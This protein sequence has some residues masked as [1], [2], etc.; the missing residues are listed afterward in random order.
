MRENAKAGPSKAPI[1]RPST[2][3]STIPTDRLGIVEVDRGDK[4]EDPRP[5]ER[6]TPLHPNVTFNMPY[7][8]GGTVNNVN[9]NIESQ[10]NNTYHG[11]PP[12]PTHSVASFNDAPVDRI[13]PCFMGREEDMHAI[14]SA[15]RSCD[16]GAPSRYAVWGMPGLGK[17]QLA[18]SYANV[19]FKAGHHTHV[20]WIPAM[21]LEKVNQGLVKVLDLTQHVDR[22]NPD[23]G[24]RLTAARLCLEQFD[25]H[26]K[27]LIILDDVTLATLDFLREHLPRQNGHGSILITTRTLEV[28]KAVASVAGQQH[29]VHELKA[30]STQ[31]SVA[32]LF[33]SAGIHSSATA[34]LESAQKF[35]KKIG[36]LPLAVE[37]AGSYMRRSGLIG[38]DQLETLYDQ[39]G[40]EEIIGWDNSLTTYQ[41][42]SVLTTIT[43]QLQRLGEIDRHL[44][45]LLQ[46]LSFL[47]LENIPLDIV[48]LGARRVARRLAAKPKDSLLCKWV[49]QLSNRSNQVV[50]ASADVSVELRP[51]LELVC[52]EKWLR[53]ALRHLEELSLAQPRYDKE[54][55]LHIH[56]LIQLVLQNSMTAD[57]LG[58]DPHCALAA[59]L[60]R[61]A[62]ETL[63]DLDSPDTWTEFE[64]FVPHLMALLKHAGKSTP[65][66]HN[67]NA[68]VAWYFFRRGR[69]DEAEA[70]YRR[71]L[72]GQEEG[73]GADHPST[74]GTVNN[75]A[76][77]Y[78]NQGRYTEAEALYQRALEGQEQ[79][80]GPDH[81]DTLGTVNNLAIVYEKQGKYAEAEELYQRALA[82]QEKQFGPD[83][84]I[85]LNTVNNLG[86]LYVLWGNY[87]E[88]E[89]LCKRG[90]EGFEQQLGADHPETLNTVNSIA[91]LYRD[92]GRY[93][94]ADTFYKRALAGQ[95]RQ[96]GAD[97][98]DT[99]ETINSL[100]NLRVQQGRLEEAEILF[101]R[102]LTGRV[103]VI[104][105]RHPDTAKTIDSL[106]RLHE[107]QGRFE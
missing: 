93:T 38:A 44:L 89:P 63:G 11:V 16:G 20:I 52:S 57:Q 61:G 95:Q 85:T 47:D 90:L 48:V 17:S 87:E 33:K 23:Q 99:L 37:Q 73:L 19:S 2:V 24:A 27:W 18:L 104:G 42:T 83:Q 10:I 70:L 36:C 43:I 21:T 55:S 106:A 39:G 94:E 107:K 49:R 26:L 66:L 101:N 45:M 53:G 105:V 97:H 81:L 67:M 56:D 28:A 8:S 84:L 59:T 22:N 5:S 50:V 65:E 69:Y 72:A 51:L 46:V 29:P 88:A 7:I 100:A 68:N 96:L 6:P 30:L 35:V 103:E 60:L 62:F 74:L 77:L 75:L 32:L 9:G 34:D 1:T 82:G 71:I 15:V 40:L 41:H 80:V 102:A 14:T 58:E 13:S 31:K 3:L 4:L 92:Q 79:Q 12:N 25:L 64:R 98:P 86:W 76:V 54:T 78:R 91:V